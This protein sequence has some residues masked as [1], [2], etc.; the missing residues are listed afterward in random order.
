METEKTGYWLVWS[1]EHDAWW[2][3]NTSGYT[4]VKEEA[5]LFTFEEAQQIVIDGNKHSKG[6]RPEEAMVKYY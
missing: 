1:F 3:G 4:K 6:D 2:K 5:G